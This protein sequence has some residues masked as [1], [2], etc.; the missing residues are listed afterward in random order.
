MKSKTALLIFFIWAGVFRAQEKLG[1]TN[2]NYSS[3]NSIFLNPSSSV[4]SR[5][6][7][8]LNLAGLNAY[9]MTNVGYLPAF[10]V[11]NLRA[12]DKIN[13]PKIA[14][15]NLKK[16][17]LIV[18]SA[19]APAFVI[20]K[21]NYGAGFF[22][23]GRSVGEIK[24]VPFELTNFLVNP[25]TNK[26]LNYPVDVNLRNIRF[27][28]MSWVEYGLN[29]GYMIKKEKNNLLSIGGNIKYIT[30]LNVA[31]A[32]IQQLKGTIEKDRI[33]VDKIKG[34]LRFNEFGW[35]TGKGVGIDIG[36]TYKKMLDIVDRYYA[37]SKQSNC[38]YVDYKYKLGIS[39]RDVGAVKFKKNT[40][41]SEVNDAGYFRTNSD[42]TYS[43]AFQDNFNAPLTKNPILSSL[44]TSLS[45]QLDWN[46]GYHFYLNGTVVKNLV[47]NAITGVQGSNLIAICPRYEFKNFELAMPLTFQKFIY[48]QLG[49]AFRVRSFVLGFDNVFPLII[50]KNTYGLN[51]YLNLG[52]SLFKNPACRKNVR[53]IDSCPPNAMAKS[54]R[55]EMRTKSSKNKKF[56]LKRN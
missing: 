47:P 41:T 1:I 56:R 16:F 33:D 46:F 29:F 5:A 43:K 26:P 40:T 3:T 13:D 15:L 9:A 39:L 19:E 23:R 24:R 55:K 10:S 53:R 28:N 20:S 14:D 8:Q 37:N 30:G 51:V 11:W 25:D 48:P 22:I 27:S 54:K 21:R 34:K 44:P 45:V 2:S 7:M 17:L 38:K 18:A 31:Y 35:N 52:L 42:T 50:K 49:F 32:N 12:S 6:Y 36:L 4:D